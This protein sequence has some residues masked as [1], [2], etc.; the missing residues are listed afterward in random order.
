MFSIQQIQLIKIDLLAIFIF[1]YYYSQWQQLFIYVSLDFETHRFITAFAPM[2][3]IDLDFALFYIRSFDQP[4]TRFKVLY[5][6]ENERN[7]SSVILIIIIIIRLSSLHRNKKADSLFFCL[8]NFYLF[9][10]QKNHSIYNKFRYSRLQEF[11][12]FLK[13]VNKLNF[14]FN[15]IF[16]IIIIKKTLT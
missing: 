10:Y 16:K 12:R 7:S 9:L 4:L 2:N 6:K 5:S 3:L 13:L 14:P 8:F 1:I 15:S 11:F